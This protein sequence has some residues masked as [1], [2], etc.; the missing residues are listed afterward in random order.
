MSCSPGTGKPPFSWEVERGGQRALPAFAVSQVSSAQNNQYSKG[1]YLGLACF[2]PLLQW[3][4]LIAL[5]FQSMNAFPLY[6]ILCKAL[7]KYRQKDLC[8]HYLLITIY[9]SVLEH[10]STR[11]SRQSL[12]L[13]PVCDPR[14]YVFPWNSSPPT[15]LKCNQNCWTGTLNVPGEVPHHDP[16]CRHIL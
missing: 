1:A 14:M 8:G 16:Q 15:Y 12:D 6:S 11:G 4:I 10:Y 3:K 2:K 5:V 7:H 9:F 13:I